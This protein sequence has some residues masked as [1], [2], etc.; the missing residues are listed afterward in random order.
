[1][2]PTSIHE[3]ACSIMSFLGGQGSHIARNCAIDQQTTALIRPLAW[4]PP[5]TRGGAP[6]N[7]KKKKKESPNELF[8]DYKHVFTINQFLSVGQLK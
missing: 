2:N 1:M 4:E 5:Y 7:K 8:Y 3:D 6:K